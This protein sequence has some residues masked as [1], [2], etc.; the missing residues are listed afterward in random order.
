M[1]PEDYDMIYAA[2]TRIDVS[3]FWHSGPRA[4][5]KATGIDLHIGRNIYHHLRQLPV[6]DIRI[7][8][9][10][11]DTLRVPRETFAS[12]F[13]AWRDGYIGAISGHLGWSEDRV[14]DHFNATIDCI[15]DPDGFALWH[16]PVVT[17]KVR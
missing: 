5:M 9:V 8:Y 15:R 16:V 11:V 17:A 3:E 12:I 13:E 2:P 4:Y 1:I 7:E 14:R 6:D 10:A